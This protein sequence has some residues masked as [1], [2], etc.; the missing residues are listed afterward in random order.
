MPAV[1]GPTQFTVGTT[2]V[3]VTF[4]TD[5]PNG[6]LIVGDSDNTGN[7]YFGNASSVT[8]SNGAIVPNAASKGSWAD[9]IPYPPPAPAGRFSQ[10][11]LYLIASEAA[12]T[13]YIIPA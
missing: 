13:V 9:R 3:S 5:W 2:A 11:T 12:Q 8:T 6:I 7:L 4:T 10:V 1:S